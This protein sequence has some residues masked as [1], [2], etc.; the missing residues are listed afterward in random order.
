MVSMARLPAVDHEAAACDRSPTGA[1][2]WVLPLA[3]PSG[4]C[5]Y[6]LEV[7]VFQTTYQNPRESTAIGRTRY[8]EGG[9]PATRRKMYRELK[10]LKKAPD[11]ET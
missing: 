7:R 4:V 5:C 10:Q 11:E 2:H 6:C 9:D 3:S 8:R 1:H